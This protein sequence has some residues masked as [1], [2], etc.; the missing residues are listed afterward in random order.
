MIIKEA[1]IGSFAGIE[2]KIIIFDRGIN[3]IYGENEVGKSRI[4][5]FIKTMLY[6]LSNKRIKGESERKK[7]MPFNG[8]RIIGELIVQD[9]DKEYIIKRTFGNTKKEDTS[10]IL[11]YLTGEEIK[12]M[13]CA[14][15]GKSLLGINKSTFEKTLYIGQLAVSVT[16][17][18]EE[19]IMDKITA[20]FGCGEHE[21]PIAKAIEKIENIK[22]TYV[23]TRGAGSLD[24]LK[25]KYSKLVE[26]RYEGYKLSE[27]NLE[28]EGK[29]IE[30]KNRKKY[31]LEQIDKLE[32]YKKYL[33]KIKLKKEYKEIISYL[34]KSEEL[35]KVEATLKSN[36]ERDGDIIDYDFIESLQKNNSSYLSLMD[37]R[38][39]LDNE[40]MSYD[41]KISEIKEELVKYKFLDLFG[42][43]IKNK[44]IKLKY[45][46][47]NI[48]EKLF[49]MKGLKESLEKDRE[50]LKCKKESLGYKFE[51]LDKNIEEINY[52]LSQYDFKL[53]SLKEM[54]E[55]YESNRDIDV[56][57]REE[58]V[59]LSLS[60]LIIILG[61]ILC[62]LKGF[63]VYLGMACFIF[64]LA[65]VYKGIIYLKRLEMESEDKKGISKIDG[66]IKEIE[67]TLDNYL[68]KLD[69]KDYTELINF[70]NMYSKFKAFEDKILIR[71]KEKEKII[72]E[73]D[74]ESL[75][76]KYLKNN[77]MLNSLIRLSKCNNIDEVLD[78]IEKYEFLNN[79]LEVVEDSKVELEVKISDLEKELA[80]KEEKIR[81]SLEVMG[82]DL[83]NL[84]DIDLYI[85]EYK[86]KIR[87][88][89][90][91]HANL[92]SMEETY[93]VLLNDRDIEKI[94]ED[95]QD[96]INDNNNY[97]YESEEDIE[98]E[99]KKRSKE[100]LE[101]EKY[102]KDLENRISNRYI[103]KRTLPVIEE[104]LD[105]V[106]LAIIDG[107]SKVKALDIA[108]NTMKES[109]DEVRRDIGP[110]LNSKIAENFKELTENKYMEVKLGENYEMTVRDSLNL[111]KGNYLSNGAKDQLYLSLRIA[112]VEL[113]FQEE[114]VSLILD[115]AFVQYD[116]KRREKA[117]L[118]L[119]KK[120]KGQVLIFT[121]HT[122]EKEIMDKNNIKINN[123]QL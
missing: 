107:E 48:K 64:A 40:L 54:A 70:V 109:F 98:K 85:K 58:K 113:L 76:K 18:K 89:E 100:L 79:N 94:K 74:Y 106:N 24:I 15:P 80:E 26:E 78:S 119:N 3:I 104:E 75:D 91:V 86:N 22:K 14:E 44:L 62:F 110:A 35:K 102:I 1:R 123:I 105:S 11:D 61:I 72:I 23:T 56:R 90:E 53:R 92:I 121:C 19:E 7:F 116:N 49:L 71:I 83:G 20:L 81:A 93:K 38:A 88:K 37:K 13:N 27:E 60:G 57:I 17:D 46:Q 55:S 112:L 77:E 50:N 51:Y 87:K 43:N 103:G 117:L 9:K 16:K 96:V 99:E 6:G 21:V 122:L 4:E 36:L 84:L 10:V 108:I 33:K 82:L 30:E 66:E 63:F 95:L 25:K 120:Y 52:T 8:G 69:A 111:F 65:A 114:D 28:L 45:E 67:D 42:D 118:I 29:L 2:N 12:N 59:K 97:E 115:D 34:K 39:E 47:E 31:I 101:C 41:K 73:E 5:S 32:L 68:R